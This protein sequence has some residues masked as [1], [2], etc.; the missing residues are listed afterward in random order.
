MKTLHRIFLI[1]IAAMFLATQAQAVLF[2]ARPYDPNLQRW[3]TRDPIGERGG[4]NLYVYVDNNPVN[5]IDPLGFE[6]NPISGLGGAWNSNP[7][8]PGGSFYGPGLYYTPPSMPDSGIGNAINNAAQSA[9]DFLTDQSMWD[10]LAMDSD[11][12]SRLAEPLAAGLGLGIV[13]LGEKCAVK[14]AISKATQ[15]GDRLETTL[16]DGT[17]VIFRR[18]VGSNAHP[19]PG[20]PNPIDHI[21]IEIM[22]PI[23]GRVGRYEPALNTHIVLNPSGNPIDVINTK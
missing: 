19:L 15:V 22:T 21:N 9:N 13:K 16:S 1:A 2:F 20:Y 17:K 14:S 8:G 4:N 23:P 10:F 3:I 11:N 12:A 6:G 5:K 18:D 7:D